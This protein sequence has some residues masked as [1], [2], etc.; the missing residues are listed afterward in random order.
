MLLHRLTHGQYL[1]FRVFLYQSRDVRRGWRGWCPE[2]IFQ[3]PLA[4]DRRCGSICIGSHGQDTALAEQAA[5]G[6]IRK[7][8]LAKMTAIDLRDIVV[9]GQPFIKKAV[10]CR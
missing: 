6:V 9:T 7:S 5:T 2:D 3:N 8:D 1:A 4:A 10:V